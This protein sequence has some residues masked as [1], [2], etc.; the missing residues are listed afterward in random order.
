MFS[1]RI[2]SQYKRTCE[3]S[4]ALKPSLQTFRS[5]HTSIIWNSNK[6]ISIGYNTNKTH[7]KSLDFNY[8]WASF[9][10]HAELMSVLRG[11]LENYKGFSIYIVRT[12]NNNETALSKPCEFCSKLIKLMQFEEIFYSGEFGECCEF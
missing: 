3:I 6:I 1:N 7:P 10:V 12:D 9:G 11:R 4:K 5:F 2:I 8:P